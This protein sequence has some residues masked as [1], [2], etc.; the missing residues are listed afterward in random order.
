MKTDRIWCTMLNHCLFNLANL[1][2]AIV[3]IYV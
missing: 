3:S 2:L 1:V